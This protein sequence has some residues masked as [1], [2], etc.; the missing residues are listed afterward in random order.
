MEYGNKVRALATF[1]NSGGYSEEYSYLCKIA[2]I[3][4][5]KEVL[6]A[7]LVGEASVEGK[8]GMQSVYQVIMNRAN[9]A[10]KTKKQIVLDPEQFSC[11]NEINTSN[12]SEVMSYIDGKRSIPGGKWDLAMSVVESEEG[13]EEL[14]EALHYYTGDTPYW[15]EEPSK[16]VYK[17][18]GG[19]LSEEMDYDQTPDP[20][21]EGNNG[22]NILGHCN[23]GNPC[24]KFIKQV[25]SHIFG[26]NYADGDVYKGRKC[27]Y[28]REKDYNLD[29][30]A[31]NREG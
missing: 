17:V 3:A 5:E 7:T 26:I 13:N 27:Y 6:A 25:G 21:S 10:G 15:A 20:H 22:K 14:S 18:D 9:S 11:W 4:T 28:D 12:N 30:W 19:S 29:R 24:W 31:K 1:L 23:E 8:L 16:C 2:N